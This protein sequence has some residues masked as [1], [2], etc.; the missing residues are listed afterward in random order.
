MTTDNPRRGTPWRKK[1]TS[2][3]YYKKCLTI[4]GTYVSCINLDFPI[5]G[6]RISNLWL[7]TDYGQCQVELF[8]KS[9]EIGRVIKLLDIVGL[10]SKRSAPQVVRPD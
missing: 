7:P 10:A 1:H 3:L 2:S 4:A 5:N 6:S 8:R 9:A